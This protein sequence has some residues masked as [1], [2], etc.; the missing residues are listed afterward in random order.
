VMGSKWC[1]ASQQAFQFS[2]GAVSAV[3][4]MASSSP[5]VPPQAKVLIVVVTASLMASSLKLLC[6]M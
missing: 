6:R 4:V 2:S 1:S 3:K 5:E